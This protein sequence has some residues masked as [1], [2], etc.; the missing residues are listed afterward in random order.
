MTKSGVTKQSIGVVGAG[1]VGLSVARRLQQSMHVEVTV[2]EKERTVAAQQTGHN[3]NVVHSGVY[4]PPR[5]LTAVLCRRGGELLRTYCAEHGLPYHAVGK[6]II[7]RR[8]DELPRLFD[9][10]DRARANGIRGTRLIG[11]AELRGREPHVQGLSALL[12]PETAVVDFRRTAE[13][14]ASDTLQEGGAVIL[15]HPVTQIEIRSCGVH[16]ATEERELVFDH[17]VVC[18]HLQSSRIARLAGASPDPV[19][20]PFR[21]E[22]YE[23]AQERSDLIRG[24]VDP[25]PGPLFP[26]LGVHFT[27]SLSGHVHV[28]PNAVLALSLEGYRW[29]DVR[30][31]DFWRGVSDPGMRRLARQHWPMGARG[32]GGSLSKTLFLRRARDYV[33]ELTMRDLIRSGAGVRAQALHR[34]GSLVD[35]FVIDHQPQM[36]FVRNAPSPAATASLPIAE[37]GKGVSVTTSSLRTVDSELSAASVNNERA[38]QAAP[39][40]NDVRQRGTRLC[41]GKD[42]HPPREAS[43]RQKAG[44]RDLSSTGHDHQAVPVVTFGVLSRPLHFTSRVPRDVHKAHNGDRRRLRTS[45]VRSLSASRKENDRGVSLLRERYSEGRAGRFVAAIETHDAVDARRLV[46]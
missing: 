20:I 22:C 34:D 29:R 25:V 16:L 31:E 8:D 10:A 35:D 9:L 6:V 46:S 7:A 14:L 26:F 44:P 2:I 13:Q 4:Y 32:I 24:L 36:T 15:G 11:A 12:V 21:G 45:G 18:A 27:R 28:G 42:E 41:D 40:M 43:L 23:I 3:S 39:L 19:I 1:I 33:P 5:S 37:L 38:E 30:L 17:V